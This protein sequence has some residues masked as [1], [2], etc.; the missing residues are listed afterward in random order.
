MP[1]RGHFSM[2]QIE[3]KKSILTQGGS[4]ANCM[5]MRLTCITFKHT[6]THN[7]IEFNILQKDYT[8][9]ETIYKG[10]NI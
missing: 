2:R 1:H 9:F 6:H 4:Q 10:I 3:M 8:Y 7:L 5:Y